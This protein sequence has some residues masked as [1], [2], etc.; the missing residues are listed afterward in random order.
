[1]RVES[2]NKITIDEIDRLSAVISSLLGN[3]ESQS[4]EDANRL[5]LYVEIRESLYGSIRYQ[6]G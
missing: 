1:M 5:K 2:D 3:A 6:L 4:L